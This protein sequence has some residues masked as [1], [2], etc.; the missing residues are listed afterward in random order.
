MKVRDENAIDQARIEAHLVDIASTGVATV[1]H[2]HLFACH[3]QCARSTAFFIGHG[4][5]CATYRHVQAIGQVTH[6][7]TA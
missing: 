7:I 2:K 1:K 6:R 4:R 5:T 3:D